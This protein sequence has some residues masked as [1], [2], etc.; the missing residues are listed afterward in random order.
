MMGAAAAAEEAL[1]SLSY[2]RKALVDTP[3]ADPKLMEQAR[4]IETGIRAAMRELSGDTTVGRRSEARL[5]SLME[6]VSAQTGSTG[7]ITKTVLR[8]YE[9]AAGGFGAVLERLRGLIERDLR[10]LGSAMEAAGAPWTPGRGLPVW[11][12]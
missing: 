12:K 4:A 3:K 11:R 6:R 1:K 7:P 8:D 10:A 9:I 5:P 2:M